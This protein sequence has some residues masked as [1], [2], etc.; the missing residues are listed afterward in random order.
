[1]VEH[2]TC[3]SLLTYIHTYTSTYIHIT[4]NI[5]SLVVWPATI[6]IDILLRVSYSCANKVSEYAVVVVVVVIV[7]YFLIS[8][9]AVVVVF[10]CC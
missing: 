10:V 7:A 6:A 8:I 1:M 9:A 2:L 4:I 5:C 3:G